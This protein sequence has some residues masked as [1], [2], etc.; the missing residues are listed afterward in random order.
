LKQA[1]DPKNILNPGK[2][3][4]PQPMDI[5]LRYGPAYQAVGWQPEL[6]FSI[7][8]A[9]GLVDA[10]ELCNGAGV[11]RKSES[12]MC[13]SF[14]AS[15]EE[16]HS[17]RGRANLLRNLMTNR[18]ANYEFGEKAVRE[19]LDLCLAC[20]GCKAECPSAVDMAKLKYEF[21]NH[22]YS[23]DGRRHPARDYV[24]GYI[25][26]VGR[27]GYLTQPIS[28][29]LMASK[30]FRRLG[31]QWI[32]I[33]SHR[34]LPQLA[35]KRLGSTW[36]EMWGGG[37]AQKTSRQ[38]L[39][40]SD[41][42]GEYFQTQ[43]SVAALKVL[44]ELGY[45]VNLLPV[46][47]AGRTLVSKGFLAAARRHALHVLQAIQEKDPHGKMPVIGV[48]PS[49]IYTLR[50]EYLDMFPGNP[51]VRSL[52]QRSWTI[53]EFLSRPDEKGQVLWKR[54]L[55]GKAENQQVIFHAHCYQRAC[56]PADD[57]F[58]VGAEA[59]VE[60]LK[61]LGYQVEVIDDGCCGVA[62]AFGYEKEHYDFS[63]KVGELVLLPTVREA[64]K[65]N[66]DILV[67]ASGVSCQA[68]IEHGAR[69]RV[70]HPVELAA[71]N[72]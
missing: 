67:S 31:E 56:P 37:E 61:A 42:F 34:A 30:W 69:I 66:P 33:S 58:P 43:S 21:F 9:Q 27:L 65:K 18:F 11:C 23:R 41:A 45:Q 70:F 68:Q 16:M 24:F 5:N 46:L 51:S 64:T 26:L 22:Y 28:R 49:E 13:P 3:V 17:T 50:D 40:L 19:A 20:K 62:G 53:E 1:A 71:R 63:L 36:K 14:Q 29:L 52:A 44:K 60:L 55:S 15:Q 4:S 2:I 38:V 8:G 59:S 12:V 48:E 72:I 35:T 25:H 39:F 6:S 47:G 10:V 54:L 32:G 7:P 57:G